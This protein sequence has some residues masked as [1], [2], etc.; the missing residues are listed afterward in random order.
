MQR[1][2]LDW[3]VGGKKQRRKEKITRQFFSGQFP[4]GFLLTLDD[5]LFW[6]LCTSCTPGLFPSRFPAK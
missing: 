1:T 6:S 2:L 5:Y 3:A 4:V